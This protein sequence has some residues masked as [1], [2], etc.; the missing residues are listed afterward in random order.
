MDCTGTRKRFHVQIFFSQSKTIL[1]FRRTLDHLCRVVLV[2]LR[3]GFRGASEHAE[4]A[5][6]HAAHHWCASFLVRTVYLVL[7]LLRL[8]RGDFRPILVVDCAQPL[9]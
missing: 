7:Y 6:R 4:P 8:H 3:S 9:V 1:H 5:A 2:F